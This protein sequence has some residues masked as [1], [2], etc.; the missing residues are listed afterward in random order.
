M[1]HLDKQRG[2]PCDKCKTASYRSSFISG[3]RLMHTH[4]HIATQRP[5]ETHSSLRTCTHSTRPSTTLLVHTPAHFPAPAVP[6]TH[7]FLPGPGSLPTC[8]GNLVHRHIQ[9]L[10]HV[11][12][13]G[14]D[15]EAS[16]DAGDGVAQSDD[17]GV[18]AR[19]SPGAGRVNLT[20]RSPPPSPSPRSSGPGIQEAA[21]TDRCSGETCYRRQR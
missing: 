18:S 8:F 19:R 14:E 10:R 11:A 4:L 13:H 6:N 17:E 21:L 7:P 20:R 15:G 5:T 2:Y 16:Q 3:H 1:T 12:Q 9:L